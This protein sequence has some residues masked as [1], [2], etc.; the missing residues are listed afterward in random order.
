MSGTIPQNVIEQVRQASDIVDLIGQYVRLKKRG[1]NFT[2]LCPFHTEKTPSFSVSPDRQIYHCFGCGKGGNIFTFLMEHEN[3]TFVEAVKF[4]ARKANIIIPEKK[5]DFSARE[6]LE[7]LHYAHQ[8]ALEYFQK[9]LRS[10][11]Y[12][13]PVMNYLKGKRRLTEQSIVQFKL[14]VSGD[15]WDGL[16]NYALRKDLFP[17][18]LEKAGLIIHSDKKDSYFDRFRQRLMIP[19]FNL[20]DKPIAFG[21]RALRKG[22]TAKYMN[23]PETLLYSKSSIL[24]GLNFS[25][26]AIRE[27]NAVIIV[28]GYFDFISLF[29]AGVTNVVASSGTAFTPQQA[30]LLAR[31]AD[32]AY[33]FFDAD[34]AG[35]T[36]AVRSVDALYDAG[37]EVLVMIPPEGEDP[38]SVAIKGGREAIENIRLNALRYLDFRTRKIDLKTVGIIGKEKLI[39]ELAEVASRIAD[40]TRRQLFIDEA[41][42]R[43][44]TKSQNL[45]NLLPVTESSPKGRTLINPPKKIVD[46]E[47]ELLSLL[48]GHPEYIDTVNEE[49][50]LD[51]FQ[52]E[53]YAKIYSLMLTVYKNEGSVS[54]SMLIDMID[55]KS[56]SGEISALVQ[57]D[58]PET[59][60][61]ILIRDYMKKISY[62]KRERLIDK[63]KAELARAEET[64]D[65]KLSAR[66]AEEIA[67]LVKQ[68][69]E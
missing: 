30:R 5:E 11:K 53:N 24:Y 1:R 48:L 36:A 23:S 31:F 19:I 20:S 32:M 12:G 15:E 37:M 18:D 64:G 55:D 34:S 57:T 49:I 68:R 52:S 67:V 59:D 9:Q 38:D 41:A 25:R 2:A 39:K 66:L 50:A 69:E 65:P 62:F 10:E 13:E 7:R 45:L 33:L 22:E 44:E 61:P 21:G 14:G 46:I 3:M 29:Q 47:R 27:Q 60:I 8:V 42:E 28:E 54:E 35:Q 58:W 6:D 4:L 16:L 63:L 43:L 51:D 40:S 56:L 26:Q 17:K